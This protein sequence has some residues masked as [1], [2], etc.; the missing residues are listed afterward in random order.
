MR[1]RVFEHVGDDDDLEALFP[2]QVP[3]YHQSNNVVNG[4]AILGVV[5]TYLRSLVST[6]A[7]RSGRLIAATDLME[8]AQQLA[9]DDSVTLIAPIVVAGAALEEVLRDLVELSEATVQGP[10]L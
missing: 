1:E 10:R 2:P 3:T 7:P 4:T 6:G 9:D 5:A 8:Q